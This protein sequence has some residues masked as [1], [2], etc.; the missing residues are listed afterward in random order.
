MGFVFPLPYHL[1]GDFDNGKMKG[2]DQRTAVREDFSLYYLAT[3]PEGATELPADRPVLELTHNHGT[4]AR[5]ARPF[6]RFVGH[7]VHH[8]ET[9]L[10]T[11]TC[12]GIYTI[13]IPGFLGG[14]GFRL[15]T[16]SQRIGFGAP[17]MANSNATFGTICG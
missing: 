11:I 17:Q 16:V 10:E 1:G 13:I 6:F 15:S 5:P 2:P 9:M 12:V 3:L 8:F 7:R 14:A 4:E